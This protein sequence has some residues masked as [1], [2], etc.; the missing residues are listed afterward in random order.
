MASAVTSLA[1]QEQQ[2]PDNAAAPD[3]FIDKWLTRWPEWAVAQVFVPQAQRRVLLAWA[4]LQQ[5]L[6]DA[7]WGGQDARPG[8]AKLGWWQEELQGWSRGLRRHPLGAVLQGQAGD[9]LVLANVLPA[10]RESRER[11]ADAVA[12]LAQIEPVARAFARVDAAIEASMA[13]EALR[14]GHGAMG[15]PTVIHQLLHARL[16]ASGE[17]AVP[18]QELARAGQGDAAA[19]WA[20]RVPQLPFVPQG[21][22]DTVPPDSGRESPVVSLADIPRFRRVT[23]AL[24]R[25]R[26]EYGD[27][28]RPLPAWRALLTAWLAARN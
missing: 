5:E 10:L 14:A 28:A 18:L 19:L 21:R 27:V 8:E 23:A 17:A 4:A 11:P 25:Q 26:L 20:Q 22:R 2:V 12:A 6:T 15:N 24:A 7:A 1:E 13:G 16:L 3:S 9:W